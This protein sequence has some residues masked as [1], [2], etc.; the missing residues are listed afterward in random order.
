MN[1]MDVPGKGYISIARNCLSSARSCLSSENYGRAYA[2]YLLFLKLVPNR[3]EEVMEDFITAMRKWTDKLEGDGR[4]DHLFKCYDQACEVVPDCVGILNNIGAQL[5]RLGYIEEASL[6]IR[7]AIHINPNYV[8]AKQNLE[9]INSHLVERWHFRMLNDIARNCAYRAAVNSAVQEGHQSIL[10]IGTGT[11]ILSLYAVEAGAPQVYACEQSKTM[12]NIAKNVL[13]ANKALENISLLCKSSAELCIPRDLPNRFLYPGLQNLDIGDMTIVCTTGST[14]EDPYTTENLSTIDKGFKILS[15]VCTLSSVDF[16]DLQEL[17]TLH[18]GVEWK[19]EMAIHKTGKLDAIA[20]WFDLHLDEDIFITTNPTKKNCWEQS[21]FPVLPAH[22]RQ[23][24]SAPAQPSKEKYVKEKLNS[25][26][27]LPLLDMCYGLSPLGIQNIKNGF[28]GASIVIREEL[29]DMFYRLAQ[30]NDIDMDY[31]NL[32]DL[33]DISQL[34]D[35]HSVIICDIVEPSG[36]LR[37]RILE[38][39]A[40]LRVNCLSGNGK[41]LPGR[42]TVHGVCVESEELQRDSSVVNDDRTCGFE[43]AKYINKYQLSTHEDICFSTLC[44][45]KLTEPFQLLSFDLNE[46]LQDN[47]PPSFLEQA[48]EVKVKVIESGHVTAIIFW[49]EMEILPGYLVSTIDSCSHWKQAA[50]MIG[51]SPNLIPTQELTLGVT[52]QNSCIDIDIVH[53]SDVPI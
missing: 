29:H 2:N 13:Q 10:D 20:L 53:I 28:T 14:P 35:E 23:S 50:V 21:I 26:I 42:V 17:D 1:D 25:N 24:K 31:L 15:N 34:Q 9:N 44:H 5:F 43:I 12:Y 30:I 48:I 11:G 36:I 41:I 22:F 45:T 47:K 37:Q 46:T 6:Y 27:H 32:V 18:N 19:L 8:A 52:L 4:I 7:K 40:L 39:L 16:N 3:R 51:P 49:F 38:D 33:K